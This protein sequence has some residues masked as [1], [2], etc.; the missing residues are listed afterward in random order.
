MKNKLRLSG[1]YLIIQMVFVYKLI[2]YLLF[3]SHGAIAYI[4]SPNKKW[5]TPVSSI[6]TKIQI[7]RKEVVYLFERM[8]STFKSK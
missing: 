2:L 4:K 1:A 3:T 7:F 6:P 8:L 5:N